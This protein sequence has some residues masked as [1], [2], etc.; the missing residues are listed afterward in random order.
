MDSN[1][2]Y[3]L[4]KKRYLF[5][6]NS[7]LYNIQE[8]YIKHCLS[9]NNK[10]KLN[11][12]QIGGSSKLKIELTPE[13]IKN[14]ITE[15]FNNA[16]IYGMCSSIEDESKHVTNS[17]NYIIPPQ[18]RV[19][20]MGD[21]HGDYEVALVC[22]RDLAKVLEINMISGRKHFKWVGGK[23][24]VVILGDILD[25]HREDMMLDDEKTKT[26]VGE[27]HD[28][29]TKILKLLSIL[30][31]QA[32]YYGGR[33]IKLMGNHE[34]MNLDGN[35]NYVSKTAI[36]D[37][38][39]SKL[40][41]EELQPKK[42]LS[43]LLHSC[44]L[45]G[46]VK[47]GD[48]VFMHGGLSHVMAENIKKVLSGQEIEGMNGTSTESSSPDPVPKAEYDENE[49][50]DNKLT[51]S[52]DIDDESDGYESDI[53]GDI[54]GD[55]IIT[56]GEAVNKEEK[57]VKGKINL[58]MLEKLMKDEIKYLFPMLEDKKDGSGKNEYFNL[59][60]F[61]QVISGTNNVTKLL[62]Q[63][64]REYFTDKEMKIY[65][66]IL[67]DPFNGIL[68]YRGLSDGR[69]TTKCDELAKTFNLLGLN[70]KKTR[71][72]V[73][74]ST[75]YLNGF[76]KSKNLYMGMSF[77]YNEPKVED[78]RLV[79]SGPGKL[80]KFE[81][82]M[83]GIN[84][85]C[86]ISEKDGHVWRIDVAMSRAFDN[87]KLIKYVVDKSVKEELKDGIRGKSKY[88]Y[89]KALLKARRPQVL[90]INWDG[91]EYNPRVLMARKGLPRKWLRINFPD[92]RDED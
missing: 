73:A 34:L 6:D 69:F 44:G 90:E 15:D 49:G 53:E 54:E 45:Y 60:Y 50:D 68:W 92:L 19:Y 36:N 43:R 80:L 59:D 52:I 85:G 46:L 12:E 5:D 23:A 16:Q 21:F 24:V 41:K 88:K 1:Y 89:L 83:H 38:G 30:S 29:E 79:F 3:R 28:E 75:Q 55:N 18:K 32:R 31:I 67:H 37:T 33:L 22:L 77:I 66:N 2:K 63:K 48:W 64:D 72:V 47:I 86:N 91:K 39:G 40:R 82:Q 74:H 62:F 78:K 7:S 17:N 10:I 35:F 26:G 11:G 71:V 61:K 51:E 13:Q 4:T 65:N 81:S 20:A 87:K 14:G 8:K 9:M 42:S 25:R 56:V 58:R 57:K 76:S 27:I 70:E 84:Y